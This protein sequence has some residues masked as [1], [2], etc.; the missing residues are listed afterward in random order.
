VRG[1]RSGENPARWRGHLDHLLPARSK[2]RVVKRLTAGCRP[3]AG[4]FPSSAL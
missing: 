4:H 2:V 3:A 1:Y